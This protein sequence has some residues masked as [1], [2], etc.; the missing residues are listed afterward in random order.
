V[1]LITL[2]ANKN[3]GPNSVGARLEIPLAADGKT[4]GSEGVLRIT[5]MPRSSFPPLR[6][7]YPLLGCTGSI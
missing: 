5:K 7:F 1:N 6:K 3:E 4:V 2:D